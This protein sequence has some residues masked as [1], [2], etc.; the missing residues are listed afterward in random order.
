[1]LDNRYVG[2]ITHDTK[3]YVYYVVNWDGTP[4]E[5]FGIH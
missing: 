3:K 5:V 2:I 1:M 4:Q